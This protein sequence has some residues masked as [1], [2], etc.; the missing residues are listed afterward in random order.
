MCF[1]FPEFRKKSREYLPDR[2]HC[3]G[4]WL[5][6]SSIMRARW[7]SSRDQSLLERGSKRKSP[8]RSS[9][10][11]QA[12]L[13]TSAVSSQSAPM[14]TSGDLYCRVW[15]SSVTFLSVR[16]PLPKSA[17]FAKTPSGLSESSRARCRTGGTG[18]PQASAA[19]LSAS[20]S[21]SSGSSAGASGTPGASSF[22]PFCFFFSRFFW[23]L[24]RLP[25]RVRCSVKA[26]WA[27]RPSWIMRPRSCLW[28]STFSS[29]TSVWMT[30][31]ACM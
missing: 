2:A 16:Q 4:G 8:V 15:M 14:I 22:L 7:S 5:P 19:A 25:A 21:S 3:F 13:Q 29:F 30:P 20:A 9:K 1:S 27:C 31:R 26:R 11:M 23:L 24:E 10:N 28:T 6:S 17:S 12:A 18:R